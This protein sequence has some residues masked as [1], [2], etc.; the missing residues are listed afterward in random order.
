MLASAPDSGTLNPKCS[1]RQDPTGPVGQARAAHRRAPRGFESAEPLDWPTTTQPRR[2]LPLRHLF[3][4][5]AG[6]RLVTAQALHSSSFTSDRGTHD[7]ISFACANSP[8]SAAFLASCL[9][10]ILQTCGVAAPFRS[11][12]SSSACAP[13]P[14]YRCGRTFRMITCRSVAC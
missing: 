13:T 9:T 8:L 14:S 3:S 7:H 12:L 4:L 5:V 2:S 1:W 10:S 6:T 11:A